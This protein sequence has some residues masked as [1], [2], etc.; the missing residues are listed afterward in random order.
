MRLGLR[1]GGVLGQV[2]LS[3]KRVWGKRAFCVA[4][5]MIAGLINA[6]V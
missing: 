3:G 4:S 6:H 1:R 5:K 2:G